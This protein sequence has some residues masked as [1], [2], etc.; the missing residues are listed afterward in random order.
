MTLNEAAMAFEDATFY[1]GDDYRALSMLIDD[2]YASAS[3]TAEMVQAGEDPALTYSFLTVD[4]RG[5]LALMEIVLRDLSNAE[6]KIAAVVKEVTKAAASE[7]AD[8]KEAE[9]TASQ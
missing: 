9:S 6:E 2:I 8:R 5:Y 3:K 4:L 1:L 7:R